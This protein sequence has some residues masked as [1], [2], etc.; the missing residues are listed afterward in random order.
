MPIRK[1]P[2]VMEQKRYRRERTF[3][4][5]MERNP[6]HMARIM[7]RDKRVHVGAFASWEQ[8]VDFVDKVKKEL[9]DNLL[10]AFVYG[11]VARGLK[12]DKLPED[13]DIMFIVKEGTKSNLKHHLRIDPKFYTESMFSEDVMKADNEESAFKR[14]L[15][16]L[17]I[18]C[19]D[20]C[21]YVKDLRNFARKHFRFE[22]DMNS[23][24][25]HQLK[26]RLRKYKLSERPPELC[27][28]LILQI[29]QELGLHGGLLDSL[30]GVQFVEDL[31]KK[32]SS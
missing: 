24:I 31:V 2:R 13:I 27:R 5:L 18:L 7:I 14:R 25:E 26:K 11:G 6:A 8:A 32:H 3:Q 10:G 28:D 12:N 4:R 9:G 20:G 19:L 22:S 17:P 29:K 30:W 16:V 1:N 21:D 23:Y 15:L